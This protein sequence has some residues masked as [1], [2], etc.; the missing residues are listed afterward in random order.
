MT[1]RPP[2]VDRRG[3]P[4][5]AHPESLAAELPEADEWRLADLADELW[6]GD[7]YADLISEHDRRTGGG[8]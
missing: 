1:A 4:T 8:A 3:F 6:P 5:P 7:E 2:M